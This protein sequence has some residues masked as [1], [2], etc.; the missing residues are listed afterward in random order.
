MKCFLP[1]LLTLLL[2]V[3]QVGCTDGSNTNSGTGNRSNS[4]PDQSAV[5]EDSGGA[6]PSPTLPPSGS[7]IGPDSSCT[8]SRQL[9][10][11]VHANI[12]INAADGTSSGV[13]DAGDTGYVTVAC[14]ASVTV[15]N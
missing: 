1:L 10:V 15:F 13:L 8:G 4:L 9:F 5:T 12:I 2:L 14:S 3:A 11:G 6:S 7:T